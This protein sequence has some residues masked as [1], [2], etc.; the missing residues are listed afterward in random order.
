MADL[1]PL[2]DPKTDNL[3][4]AP[5]VQA[6]LNAPLKADAWTDEEQAFLNDLVAKVEAGTIK[7]YSPSSLLNQAVYEKLDPMARGKVDQNSVNML[8]KIRD[9]VGLMKVYNEPTYQIKNLVESLLADK[10]RLEEVGDIFII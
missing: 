4:I 3:A 1:N 9:I 5:E 10:R 8:G 2:Y 7:L 6:M